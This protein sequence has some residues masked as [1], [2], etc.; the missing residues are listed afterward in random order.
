MRRTTGRLLPSAACGLG[1]LVFGLAGCFTG[2]TA[3]S[4]STSP[5]A[6]TSVPAGRDQ[7]LRMTMIPK[8]REIRTLE[9]VGHDAP[10]GGLALAS[11]K[12]RTLHVTAKGSADLAG[13]AWLEG[14]V[15]V[16]GKT[17]LRWNADRQEYEADI[18]LRAGQ[19]PEGTYDVRAVL[20]VNDQPVTEAITAVDQ[21]RVTL[22]AQA[23][24]VPVDLKDEA[25]AFRV[26]FDTNVDV[27]GG[28]EEAGARSIVGKLRP[29][30][31]SINHILVDGHC[32]S[33]GPE[34]YNLGLAD[35]RAAAL[36]R[37]LREELPGVSIA[38]RSL[39]EADPN[40]P[41]D[42][43]QDWSLNRWARMRID[44]R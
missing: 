11:G 21:V 44:T 38:T 35:R 12:P 29:Y 25:E 28:D 8:V 26:F 17:D 32:D 1:L 31:S 23:G 27:F 41:G 9:S 22:E 36:A 6:T 37:L 33:R 15:G 30:A 18:A 34:S 39:G 24:T 40:P 16:A 20:M 43:P 2:K 3:T 14:P 42:D 10:A 7:V 5:S 13:S 4:P 19:V